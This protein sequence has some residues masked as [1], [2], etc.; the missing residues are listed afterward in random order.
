MPPLVQFHALRLPESFPDSLEAFHMLVERS[1]ALGLISVDASPLLSTIGQLAPR[2]PSDR[3]VLSDR[4]RVL[5]LAVVS[6]PWL[7]RGNEGV[8]LDISMNPSKRLPCADVFRLISEMASGLVAYD[9]EMSPELVPTVGY[10]RKTAES[11]QWL[12]TMGR[13]YRADVRHKRIQRPRL[14]PTPLKRAFGTYTVLAED[15]EEK[16]YHRWTDHWRTLH[17]EMLT[18]SLWRAI[19]RSAPSTRPYSVRV[20][21]CLVASVLTAFG[22]VTDKQ[23]D[24][25]AALLYKRRRQFSQK[26]L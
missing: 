22:V 24:E 4:R 25:L 11:L 18:Q 12:E 15:L 3:E 19:Q 17:Q 9:D 7:L 14:Q 6:L 23:A 2:A 21:S 8:L 16:A 10:A 13:W 5:E 20:V 26:K 1:E